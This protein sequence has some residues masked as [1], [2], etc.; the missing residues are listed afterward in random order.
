LHGAVAR[1]RRAA[2]PAPI[3]RFLADRRPQRHHKET[4]TMKSIFLYFLGVPV[5][6]IILLNLFGVL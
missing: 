1:H 4:A 2:T 5:V 6:L 3:V